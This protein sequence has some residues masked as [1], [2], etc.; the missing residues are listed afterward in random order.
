MPHYEDEDVRW[1]RA[2]LSI[3]FVLRIAKTYVR[4][5]VLPHSYL[6]E[7]PRVL[8]VHAIHDCFDRLSF[9]I[10]I[11]GASDKNSDFSS[12]LG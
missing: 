12:T 2:E 3:D 8:A 4:H 6:E 10:D 9:L 1:I 5:C 7:V 11:R